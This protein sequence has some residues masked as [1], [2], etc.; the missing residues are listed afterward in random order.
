MAIVPGT[1]RL[2]TSRAKIALPL[3][4]FFALLILFGASFVGA[5]DYTSPNFILR[6]PVIGESAGRSTS[7]NF[8]L[9]GSTGELAIGQSASTNFTYQS[10]SNYF[11]VTVSPA[12]PPPA[13]PPGGGGGGTIIST[14]NVVFS[15][16]AYPLSK[17]F[18]LK[19]GQIA[20][21][22][23]AGPDANFLVSLS[24]VS[25]GNYNFSLY[26][27]DS[28]GRRSSLFTFPIFITE[29]ASTVIS[30]IFITPTID[31][32]KQEVRRGDNIAI[33]GKTSP[34]ADVVIAVN[35]A[36]TLFLN[37]KAQSDGAYFYNLDT[38][39]IE[40]GSHSAK[41]KANTEGLLSSF[42]KSVGFTVGDRTIIKEP[43]SGTCPARADLNGDC[44]VDLIDF[45][46][47]AYW[48][49]RALSTEFTSIEAKDLDGDGAITLRDFSIMAFYW[50]G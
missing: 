3:F 13:S 8:E 2:R 39:P 33:L 18:V 44:K 6:D 1:Y 25:E 31:V 37:A 26:G 29:G 17:V 28:D 34:N 21:S 30:G 20:V 5:V 46:L 42:G 22:T 40:S 32:D 14:P 48:Y 9:F 10:G 49:K 16:K 36:E 43:S 24:N 38:S 11:T 15:G 19:D 45:S 7:S 35:S 50:T 23:I 4:G 27:E 12:P 41:A 47:A